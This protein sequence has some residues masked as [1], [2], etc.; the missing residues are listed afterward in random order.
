MILIRAAMKVAEETEILVIFPVP[1]PLQIMLQPQRRNALHLQ[2]MAFVALFNLGSHFSVEDL[3]ISGFLKQ[4]L[5]VRHQPKQIL[6]RILCYSMIFWILILLQC[7]QTLLE[8]ILLHQVLSKNSLESV[9]LYLP[10]LS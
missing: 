7:N 2:M 5:L 3:P 6:P 10:Y 9:I 1:F 8:Q 4:P